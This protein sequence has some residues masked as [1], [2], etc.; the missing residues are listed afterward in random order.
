MTGVSAHDGGRAQAF[1][2]KVCAENV[3]V[4]LDVAGAVALDPFGGRRDSLSGSMDGQG[5]LRR[6]SHAD[7]GA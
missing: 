4:S 7:S 1:C 5:P 6:E 2:Y 3:G